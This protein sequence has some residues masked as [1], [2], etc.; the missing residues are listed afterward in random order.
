M[1][2]LWAFLMEFDLFRAVVACDGVH[3]EMITMH[4]GPVMLPCAGRGCA[5]IGCSNNLISS[6]ACKCRQWR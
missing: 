2:H 3:G 4:S 1:K 5:M 6:A